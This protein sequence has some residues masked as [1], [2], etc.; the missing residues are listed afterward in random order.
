[1]HF[2]RPRITAALLW[3]SAVSVAWGVPGAESAPA[4]RTIL[5]PRAGLVPEAVMRDVYEEVKTP[6]KYGVILRG[7]DGKKLDCPS[8]FRHNDTWYMIYVSF[9]G[10]GYETALAESDDLLAWRP[11]GKLMT[12]DERAWDGHQQGGYL[13]LQDTTWGGGG[14]LER[15]DGRYWM[16]YLGGALKG[17][18]TDPLAIGMAW[19]TDDPGT[20]HRWQR[21]GEPVLS[22]DQPDVR[23]FEK[24]T[25]YKSNVIRDP[26]ERLGYPF[27]MYYNGKIKGGYEKIG[28]AVSKDMLHWIRYGQDAIVANG[29]DRQH[30]ITGDPQVVR[31]G[32]VWV[33][34][35]FGAFWK[36]NAFDTFACSYD[37]VHWTQWQGPHLV[38]PSEPWDRQYAHKPWVVKHDGVV[39]HFYCAVGDQGRVLAVATSRDLRAGKP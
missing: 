4:A 26:E 29:I 24:V 27:V 21:F 15:Y 1:M 11:L 14:A 13:A 32:D 5:N 33:M 3:L 17:Y 23:P 18:E 9:D 16:S 10:N 12:F 30:G 19:T 6:Y 20:A 39:Y 34:F 35:Y 31:I 2:H 8:V 7:E 37:L 38:E 36:P 22:R 25:L 28:M